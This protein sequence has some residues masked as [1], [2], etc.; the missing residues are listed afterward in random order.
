MVMGNAVE[1]ASQE[2]RPRKEEAGRIVKYTVPLDIE[3]VKMSRVGG[4]QQKPESQVSMT[5]PAER[6]LFLFKLPFKSCTSLHF[7]SYSLPFGYLAFFLL[8]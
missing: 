8:D 1:K 3:M 7:S 5:C 6:N 4:V 2:W